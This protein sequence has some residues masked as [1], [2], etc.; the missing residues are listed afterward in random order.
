MKMSEDWRATKEFRWIPKQANENKQRQAEGWRA[1]WE[2]LTGVTPPPFDEHD[3]P[4]LVDR[5]GRILNHYGTAQRRSA[6]DE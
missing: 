4:P 6:E 5:L 3:L 1:R 2:R